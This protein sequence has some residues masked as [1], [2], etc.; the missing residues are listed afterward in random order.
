MSLGIVQERNV[1]VLQNYHTDTYML[2]EPYRMIFSTA[3]AVPKDSLLSCS[4]INFSVEISIER[5]EF[6]MFA[7]K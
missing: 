6:P 1:T 5:V 4:N 7:T 3:T 2:Q